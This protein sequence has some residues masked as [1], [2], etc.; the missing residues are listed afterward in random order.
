M[1]KR[2]YYFVEGRGMF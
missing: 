2:N 1:K